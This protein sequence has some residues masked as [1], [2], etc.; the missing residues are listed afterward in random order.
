MLNRIAYRLNAAL[1]R[2]LPEQRLFLRS[3]SETRFIR[4]SPL[5]QAVA[6]GGSAL[7]VG[8]TIIATAIL[9]MDSVGSGN[10]RDQARREQIAYEQRLN[11]VTAERDARAAEAANAQDRFNLALAQVSAMQS[12]L[13]TSEDRRKELETGI[14]V[15]QRTLRRTIKER[16]EARTRLATAE[17]ALTAKAGTG[18]ADKDKLRD[19]TQTLDFMTVAL[20]RAAEERDAIAAEALDARKE[21]DEI[22]L[23]KR[24][25]EE[26]NDRIFTRLEEAVSISMAPLDKMFRAAGLKP[27]EVLATVRSGYSGQGGPLTPIAFSTK[28]DGPTPDEMRANA[29]LAGFDTLNLYRLAAQKVPVGLPLR[30]AFRFTS[31]FGYRVDPKGAG[32]RF[33]EGVDLAGNYGSPVYATADGVV[34]HAG[35]STGYGRL[36]TIKHAFGLETRYG[37]LSQIR[38]TVGQ[39]VSRGQRIGDMGNSGRSTGTHLHYEVRTAGKPVNPMTYIKAASNV[40]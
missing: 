24:L 21:A 3:D 37:H 2:R 35:W 40:F 25:M 32:R 10:L 22:A 8:W 7:F 27:E 29:I 5:S 17:A 14:D 15:I 33:H 31:P 20:G 34:V 39:R 18:K 36:I 12:A 28:G 13:R 1:G 4:L 30:T 9:L 6:L 23:D 26:R 19:L 38:V 16:D 11:A